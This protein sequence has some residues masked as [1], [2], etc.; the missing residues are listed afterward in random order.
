MK[1]PATI[2]LFASSIATAALAA[3][4]ICGGLDRFA[5]DSAFDHSTITLSLLLYWAAAS[6]L[7]LVVAN[8]KQHWKRFLAATVAFLLTVVAAELAL[9]L[10]LP[11]LA[12]HRFAHQPSPQ[13]H[14]MPPPNTRSHWGEM[15][16][17]QI[18][19]STN[20]DGLRTPF[21]R[22]GFRRLSVRIACLGDSFTFGAGVQGEEAYPAMLQ[23]L[24]R[25]RSG[26]NTIGVLNCGVESHSP[27]LQ[28]RVLRSMAREYQP[29]IV[30]LMIDC[31]DI[32]DD[33]HYAIEAAGKPDAPGLFE[34]L[35]PIPRDAD[36]GA[37]WR[38]TK[39]F[40]T[41]PSVTAP[42][43][44]IDRLLGRA[45][46]SYDYYDFRVTI[47]GHD[48]TNRFFIY[49]HP[50]QLT[51][52][53]FDRTWQNVLD[54]AAQCSSMQARFAVVVSP[55]F[56]HWNAEE[57][58]SNWEAKDY[59]LD[60]PHQFEFFRYFEEKRQD[61]SFPIRQLLEDFRA[62]KT[63]PLVFTADPH[64]NAQGHSFVAETLATWLTGDSGLVR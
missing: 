44:L 20:A 22:E 58:P 38:C 27:M 7:V 14:H 8:W 21:T 48:E 25:Q 2:F 35:P 19:V 61:V 42:L 10:T 11:H 3:V 23:T 57:C 15:E 34:T 4:V 59:R 51:R 52:P 12:L 6:G 56:H 5:H 1:R 32:G 16:G 45:S 63:S 62:S 26:D 13:F 33:H 36:L 47:G 55:R 43:R 17:R 18:V 49:R 54:I 46:P 53:F 64:W 41:H 24:L 60:E 40:R 37:V 28:G 29:N 30:L 50:L 9:R 31:T 39:P